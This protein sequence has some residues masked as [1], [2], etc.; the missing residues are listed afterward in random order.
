MVGGEQHRSGRRNVLATDAAKTKVDEEEGQ[1]DRP[2]GPVEQRVDATRE[3]LLAQGVKARHPCRGLPTSV[4]PAVLDRQHQM[5]G[6]RAAVLSARAILTRGRVNRIHTVD[7]HAGDP[8]YS[9]KSLCR[10]RFW[11]VLAVYRGICETN[12]R[13]PRST[14]HT[15]GKE[16]GRCTMNDHAG[17]AQLARA[18][19]LVRNSLRYASEKY[20]AK[21]AR[22]LREIYTAPTV[23]AAEARCEEF[24][25]EWRT[26]YPAMIQSWE[27]FVRAVATTAICIPRRALIRSKNARS[28][29]GVLVATHAAST[30]V[31]TTLLGDPSMRRGLSARLADPRVQP[32]IADQPVWGGEPREVSDRRD[33]RQ[34]DGRVDTAQPALLPD[35]PVPDGRTVLTSQ[36]TIRHRSGRGSQTAST[37]FHTGYKRD[38]VAER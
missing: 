22:S 4:C 32:E 7:T 23:E 25:Q 3:G 36:D 2:D 5:P 12:G 24:A 38:R 31:R 30:S 19:V 16:H 28:G 17:V 14:T 11:V 20:W 21:I 29:P 10:R 27:E 18:P 26:L 15:I 35:A 37:P 13:Q 34:R 33:D 9:V 8:R 6:K 1:E